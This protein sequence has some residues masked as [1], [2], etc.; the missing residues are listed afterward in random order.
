MFF[1]PLPV[2]LWEGKYRE[3]DLVFLR[4]DRLG[5]LRG[6]LD[7]ADLVVEVMSE[8]E[9]NRRRDLVE[10]RSDYAR[11]GVAEY[12]I[13]DPE[14]RWIEVLTLEGAA[15]RSH[16]R[17]ADGRTLTSVM[18]PGRIPDTPDDSY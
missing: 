9:G 5:D 2:R 7:G 15:Y 13:V 1:A 3:P 14:E 16:G 17:F 18:F 11:A 12:W 4:P 6:Q 10:K 8:G